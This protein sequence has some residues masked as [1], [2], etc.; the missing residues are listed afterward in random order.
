MANKYEQKFID[1]AIAGNLNDVRDLIDNHGVDVNFQDNEKGGKGALH[2][3]SVWDHDEIIDFLIELRVDVNL[4]NKKGR[5][6]LHL[7]VVWGLEEDRINKVRTLIQHGANV[8]LTE[9]KGK[10]VLH[11]AAKFSSKSKISCRNI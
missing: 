8:H 6:P 3:A 10:S 9:H 2:H 1:A 11:R 4:K 5:S 7:A